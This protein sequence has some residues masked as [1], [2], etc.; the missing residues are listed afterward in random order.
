M[1]IDAPELI[2]NAWVEQVKMSDA[3]KPCWKVNADRYLDQL[4]LHDVQVS[5]SPA[6]LTGALRDLYMSWWTD[7]I[8]FQQRDTAK[9]R[10]YVGFKNSFGQHEYLDSP[11]I[12]VRNA[13]ASFRL[14]QHKLRIE[15]PIVETMVLESHQKI[16]MYEIYTPACGFLIPA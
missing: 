4:K 1:A 8:P 16:D 6:S 3:G 14:S 10:T 5:D 2:R 12:P 9:L 7:Q 13:V 11:N 15:R